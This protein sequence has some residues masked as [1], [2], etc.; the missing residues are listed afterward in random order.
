M[1]HAGS[2]TNHAKDPRARDEDDIGEVLVSLDLQS[3]H[4]RN[5]VIASNDLVPAFAE[6]DYGG[7]YQKPLGKFLNTSAYLPSWNRA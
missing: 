5:L 2:D 6:P 7:L 3:D 1:R 4:R